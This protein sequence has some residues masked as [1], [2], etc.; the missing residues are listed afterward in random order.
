LQLSFLH[1]KTLDTGQTQNI[2]LIKKTPKGLP[3]EAAA[4]I[5]RHRWLARIIPIPDRQKSL[6]RVPLAMAIPMIK[7]RMT[8]MTIQMVL[9]N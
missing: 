2:V 1:F 9:K 5:L 4:S 8:T 6:D 3:V 7:K